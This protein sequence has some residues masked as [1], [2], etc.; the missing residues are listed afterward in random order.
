MTP[1]SVGQLATPLSVWPSNGKHTEPSSTLTADQNHLPIPNKSV[2]GASRPDSTS[3]VQPEREAS[4]PCHVGENCNNLTD[5]IDTN[6]YTRNLEFYGSASLVVFLRDIQRMSGNQVA[7]SERS[8][9]SLLHNT[10]FTPDT[11][12]ASPLAT[13]ESG[14]SHDRYYF[15][16]ARQFL[17]AYFLNI[18]Y[19]QPLFDKTDFYSRCEDLWFNE[20]HKQSLIF[21][22]LYYAAMSLGSLVMTAEDSDSSTFDRFAWSRKLFHE[23][24]TLVTRLGTATNI[25]MAQCFYMLVS[26]TQTMSMRS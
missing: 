21:I 13:I 18:H 16:M 1:Q 23:A 8:L 26:A 24:T 15:R 4:K 19:I 7:A 10:K 20:Q 5:V 11:S 3:L 9:A 17:D 12:I 25:E 6:L 14:T 22:A 2:V